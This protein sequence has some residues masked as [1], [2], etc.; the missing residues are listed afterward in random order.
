M[1]N[2][3]ILHDYYAVII[4]D[5]LNTERHSHVAHQISYSLDA[6]PFRV[7]VNNRVESKLAILIPSL[8]SHKFLDEKGKYLSILIDNDSTFS[9]VDLN[10]RIHSIKDFPKDMNEVVK[11]LNQLGLNSSKAL[12][13]RVMTIL[14]LIKNSQN[15]ESIRLSEIAQDIGLSESRLLHLFKAEVGVP[16]RKYIL[17]KKLKRA[18]TEFSTNTGR[19]FTEIALDAGFSDSAHLSKVVKASFGL[20]PSEILKNS[21]FIKD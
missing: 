2:Q 10:E 20:S 4:S 7:E 17:W 9:E 11:L 1:N 3:I 16:F 14:D 5:S 12:D 21:Q 6:K 18:V 19:N 8:V 15:L 13:T